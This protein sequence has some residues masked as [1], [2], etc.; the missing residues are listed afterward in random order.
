MTIRVLVADDQELVRA[1]FVM[2]LDSADDI[3]V[4]GEARDGAEAVRAVRTLHP[5]VVL[6]DIRMPTMDGL[7]ATRIIKANGG[8]DVRVLILT[9]FDPDE[10]VYDALRAGASGFVLKDIPPREL[11][12]AVRVVADGEAL[13][14]PSITRR[15]VARFAEQLTPRLQCV[16]LERLT[17]RESEVLRLMARGLS[18]TE[19]G[20]ELY[21]SPTT[22]KSHVAG[23][24]AKLGCR[25]RVQAV[26]FAYEHGVVHPGRPVEGGGGGP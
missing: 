10:Y 12:T 11:L 7:E 19:I 21:L 17:G 15:L 20:D 24:L 1:G 16:E 22:I 25:D 6:M 2:I 4:V 8:G 23:I 3:D 13:L 18:N 9:T 5:D 14:A 26:V